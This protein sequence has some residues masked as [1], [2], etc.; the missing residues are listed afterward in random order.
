MAT[1]VQV[2]PVA[3]AN[4]L[5]FGDLLSALAAGWRDFRTHPW[6]GLFFGT[7]CASAGIVLYYTLFVRGQFGWLMPAI[8][9]F[10]IVAPFAAVG[11]YEVSRRAEQGLPIHSAA[12]LAALRGR[13]EEQLVMM[14]GMLFIAVSFWIGVAHGIFAIFM[15]ET[16]FGSASFEVLLSPAGLAMLGLGSLAGGLMALAMYCVTVI[17]LPMLVE[18]NVDF[19]TAIIVSL[20]VVRSNKAVML[21]WAAIIAVSLSAAMLPMFLGLL[22]VLPVLGHATWH[23]Y[24]RA[25]SLPIT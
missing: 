24:R 19:I 2:A 16:G 21:A 17:S 8:G 23:L 14:A 10:P 1:Q 3:V 11:L 13:G 12:I 5:R 22:V 4:D 7:L 6:C 15:A 9:G 25:V 18:R 20:G